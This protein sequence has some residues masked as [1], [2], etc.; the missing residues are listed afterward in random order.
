MTPG[1]W[2]TQEGGR[3]CSDSV[4]LQAACSGWF[5]WHRWR[6]NAFAATKHI[7]LW[8]VLQLEGLMQGDAC[9]TNMTGWVNLWVCEWNIERKRIETARNSLCDNCWRQGGGLKQS[10]CSGF[11]VFFKL[12]QLSHILHPME[13]NCCSLFHINEAMGTA[14]AWLELKGTIR[15]LFKRS[16]QTARWFLSTYIAD[17]LSR[18]RD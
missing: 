12:K 17:L 6:D 1:A 2:G 14:A 15:I 13:T 5:L 16:P 4:L 10:G 7:F 3:L 18:R 9:T 8:L 11:T